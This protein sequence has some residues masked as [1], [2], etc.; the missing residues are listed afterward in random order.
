[1]R[2]AYLANVGTRDVLYR[3]KL[4]YKP[5][6]EGKELLDH[7][8]SVKSKLSAPIIGA[9][10]SYILQHTEKLWYVWLFV[11]DQPAPPA[12]PESYWENDTVE[13]GE[14]LQRFLHDE[15][16]ERVEHIGCIP[17]PFNPADYNQ[18]LP[19]F[20]DRL[21]KILPPEEVDI[22]FIAPVGGTDACNVGL[23]INAV[24]VYRNKCQFIYVM[25]NGHV[26]P[27]NLHLE[28]LRDWARQ[29]AKAQLER[30][31]YAA[32]RLTL[33]EAQLGESWHLRLCNYVDRRIRFD[34]EKAKEEIEAAI[35]S[36]PAGGI[37]LELKHIEESLLPFLEGQI[38]PTSSSNE[39]AW[40]KWFNLQRLLLGEL[41][42]N[43]QLKADRGEWVD[44]L[45]R[46]FRLHEALL[47]LAFE[48][49][50][51]H[52]TK[53]NER[54]GYPDFEKAINADPELKELLK[55]NKNKDETIL[56]PTTYILGQIIKYWVKEKGHSEYGP[57]EGMRLVFE[58]LSP[59]RNKSIIA[60]GYQG[61]SREHIE[62][63]AKMPMEKLIAKIQDMLSQ[64]GVPTD[65][66]KNP[67]VLARN[68]LKK[69]IVG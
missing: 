50:T 16:G 45:G 34:F 60:H 17:M 51:R 42:F 31:D 63:K 15:F 67:Y 36:A 2:V 62:A 33:E 54:D 46:F 69:E 41:F 64:M 43:L 35:L 20:Q 38:P 5:R 49:E 30:H 6:S 68:I 26:E 24:R 53:G 10:L 58:A 29:E 55:A 27:L 57:L 1:M 7:Y 39:E 37:K 61:V 66:S 52:S 22:V 65:D 32:L 11:T 19:F 23:T 47:R 3:G 40:F 44:F 8:D 48:L 9:G 21:P 25:P 4:L 18:T 13:L 14:L 12:T 59:L 28:I 56:R